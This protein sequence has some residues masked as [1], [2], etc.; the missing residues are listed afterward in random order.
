MTVQAV[1]FDIGGVLVSETDW[2]PLLAWAARLG[3]ST[4][5]MGARLG[6][7]DRERRATTGHLTEDDMR[8]G[9]SRELGLDA[10]Q[11]E[12]FVQDVWDL[13]C[14]EPDRVMIEFARSLRPTYRTGLLSNAVDGARRE[15][16]RRYGLDTLTDDLVYSHEVHLAKPD[17]AIYHLACQRLAVAPDEV[18]FIDD[19]PENVDAAAA[20]GMHAFL[21]AGDTATTIARIRA[22]AP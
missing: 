1:I 18:V 17:P 6:A 5:E 4:D 10:E 7:V 15:E 16:S 12:A 9:W 19:L 22:L 3:L 21:H 11:T 8:A 2:S 20:L 14:G 13:Y